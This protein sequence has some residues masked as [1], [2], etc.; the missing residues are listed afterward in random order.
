MKKTLWILK[1]LVPPSSLSRRRESCWNWKLRGRPGE[2]LGSLIWRSSGNISK[3]TYR[4]E[5][6]MH[7]EVWWS[8]HQASHN[9]EKSL[10]FSIRWGR[11]R[12][13]RELLS[14]GEAEEKERKNTGKQWFSLNLFLP[15]IKQASS[16]LVHSTSSNL[17]PHTGRSSNSPLST[18]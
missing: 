10:S 6:G 18:K 12:K 11:E 13:V 3:T 14:L 8:E 4:R 2:E 5:R 15:S 7:R 9:G 17:L 1:S 16:R